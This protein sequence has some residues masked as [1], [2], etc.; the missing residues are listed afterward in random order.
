MAK[1]YSEKSPTAL[2]IL[3]IDK[4]PEV[5]E[6]IKKGCNKYSYEVMTFT[7]TLPA[8][9][10]LRG[11]RDDF[12]LIL[13]DLHMPGMDGYEF[14]RFVRREEFFAP[15]IVMSSE[16]NRL[17]AGMA[18]LLG[19][20]DYWVKPLGE[21]LFQTVW[22]HVYRKYLNEKR[23]QKD[24]EKLEDDNQKRET[25]EDAVVVS[26]VGETPSSE[27]G[28][29]IESNK[30]GPVNPQLPSAGSSRPQ[31]RTKTKNRKGK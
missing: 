8:V 10:V 22:T 14:L 2:T 6:L 3:A 7:D 28:D 9:D 18:F 12:N 31:R 5:L 17:S 21:Y 4:D 15:V 19:A 26:S 27:D 1:Y 23:K 20:C 25:N 11:N 29:V 13:M 30:S 24:N 16:E